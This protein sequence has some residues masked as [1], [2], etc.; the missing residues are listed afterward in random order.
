M[1]IPE[2]FDR[3]PAR[4]RAGAILTF[5][6]VAAKTIVPPPLERIHLEETLELAWSWVEGGIVAAD[7]LDRMVQ[8]QPNCSIFICRFLAP[9]WRRPAWNIILVGLFYVTSTIFQLEGTD[10]DQLA[11]VHQTDYEITHIQLSEKMENIAV[12]PEIVVNQI[13]SNA[14]R[15]A[16]IH[17]QAASL[18]RADFCDGVIEAF[19]FPIDQLPPL[20]RPVVRSFID[21][22]P[23]SGMA[24]REPNPFPSIDSILR[25]L[26]ESIEGNSRTFSALA[27]RLCFILDHWLPGTSHIRRC[28]IAYQVASSTTRLLKGSET[29]L[30]SIL[31][32]IPNQI[33]RVCQKLIRDVYVS[34]E[35]ITWQVERHIEA[36]FAYYNQ[37]G[38]KALVPFACQS[39]YELI[40][41]RIDMYRR[42]YLCNRIWMSDYQRSASHSAQ[43]WN[44]WEASTWGILIASGHLPD[45]EIADESRKQAY[46]KAWLELVRETCNP[47]LT[48]FQIVQLIHKPWPFF[49]Q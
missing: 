17:H 19:A 40:Q 23:C 42:R 34:P 1:N 43:P 31:R 16:Q 24:P 5:A 8:F 11:E 27:T 37:I 9:A 44:C 49:D 20:R 47:K 3:L 18:T 4:I 10:I 14:L 12:Q 32:G 33:L 6:Q 30:P 46:W 38:V 45:L 22:D 13:F 48:H 25:E 35:E 15:I 39:V 26:E 41:G 21:Y 36:S 7:D 29:T 28:V 2:Q